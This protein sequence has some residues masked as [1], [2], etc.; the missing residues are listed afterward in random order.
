MG[1]GAVLFSIVRILMGTVALGD[2]ATASV[3]SR[4]KALVAG[5]LVLAGSG[6]VLLVVALLSLSRRTAWLSVAVLVAAA[7]FGIALLSSVR[8]GH[9][10]GEP[11]DGA[12]RP[13]WLR[14]VVAHGGAALL[15]VVFA[16]LMAV[17]ATKT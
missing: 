1:V 10:T 6:A 14:V 5:H 11:E 7:T 9:R 2:I 3:T 4:T 15:T 12:E 8:L 17:R 13:V 16:V